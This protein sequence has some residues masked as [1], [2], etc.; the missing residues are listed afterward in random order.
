MDNKLTDN[1]VQE[2][3][4]QFPLGVLNSPTDE[5]DYL[6]EPTCASQE[7]LPSSFS[8]D[9]NYPILNQGVVGS[10]VGHGIAET[11]SYIDAVDLSNMYSVGFI[12]SNRKDGDFSGS[13]MIPR[14]ALSNLVSDGVCFNNDFPI[15]EEYPSILNTLDKYGKEQLFKKANKHKSK[16]YAKLEVEQIKEYLYTQQKPILIVVKVYS[17]FY[18]TR[19]TKGIVPKE[20][21]G[22]YFGSHLMAICGWNKDDKLKILN[23]WGKEYG[24]NGYIYLDVDS[25]IIKELWVLEDEKNVIK[26]IIP[27]PNPV[28]PIENTLYRVQLGAFSIRNNADLLVEELRSKGIDSCIKIYPNMFKVQVGCYLVKDNAINMQNK[29]KQLG[30]DC[31]IVGQI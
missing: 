25:S 12:Y 26:P 2:M 28:K 22:T 17:S 31:F 8:L 16:A 11:K 19:Y 24:D 27:Q 4:K 18:E 20:Q 7:E 1:E 14:Q 21:Y 13:G 9:Y 3:L 29:L 6:Y 23:S 5:R 15:N 10:C 30:Y